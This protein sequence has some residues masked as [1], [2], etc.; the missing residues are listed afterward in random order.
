[1]KIVITD[2]GFGGLAVL[3]ELEKRLSDLPVL[4]KVDLIFFN[5]LY[6]QEYGYS[7]MKDMDEKAKVFNKA[8]ISIEKLFNPDLI[9]IACNTLSIV[10]PNTAFS[11]NTQT[12]V[13]GIVESGF[14]LFN[15]SIKNNSDRIVLMGTPT[16]INSNVY[17]NELVR[18]GVNEEQIVNQPCFDLETSIQKDPSS[19][20]TRNEI[21]KFVSLATKNLVDTTS[22]TYIGFCCT[23]YG[24]SKDLFLEEFK[25][26]F[27]GEVEIL[28]PNSKMIDFLFEKPHRLFKNA[29]VTV[30]L[31]TRVKLRESEIRSLSHLLQSDSPKTAE[32]ILNYEFEENLFER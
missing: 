9:L 4:E 2:S 27:I 31:V 22:K 8:L 16:T 15:N 20:E 25:N 3:A 30:R 1:M 17:K 19:N 13:N 6:S 26:R 12:K 5:S 29:D 10:Y 7:V 23:H 21:S 14:S 11:K 28:N 24:Y 18:N 32:A